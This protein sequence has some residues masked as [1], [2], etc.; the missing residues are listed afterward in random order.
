MNTPPLPE[1]DLSAT[2]QCVMCG[3]CVPHCPTYALTRNEADSPRGRIALMLGMHQ[4]R[5]EADDSTR[6]H[7]ASCLSCRAC[8]RICP[9]KVPYGQLIDAARAR[10]TPLH[11]PPR[12]I[13]WLRDGVLLRPARLRLFGTWWRLL[14]RLNLDRLPWPR[15]LARLARLV[16]PLVP[17][18]RPR[19]NYPATGPRRGAI[20]LFLGC[21]GPVFEAENL[22]AAIRVLNAWGYDVS[23]PENQ[24]CCGAMHQHGGD[25]ARGQTMAAGVETTFQPLGLDAV[26][27]VSSGCMAQLAEHTDLPVFELSDFLVRHV[28]S[29]LP[30]LRAIER[31][32]AVHLPCTQRNVLR[33]PDSALNLLRLIHGLSV[34]ALPGNDRCCGAAGT[35]MLT[36]PEQADALRAPKI[37]AF[38]TLGSDQLCSTNIGCAM[39]LGAGLR[40]MERSAEVIHPVR[41]L[42]E[43]LTAPRITSEGASVGS[44][45]PGQ[46]ST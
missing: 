6:A 11:S 26:V 25:P 31:Q 1:H 21:M 22:R 30:A 17:I 18:L 39:H 8:E 5:L 35:H 36:H 12:W 14:Q 38:R 10:I 29:P 33:R 45:P 19:A 44:Q 2:E 28:P 42:A 15:P 37:E 16:P 13:T 4:G 46:S 23:I 7:L 41:L 43:A 32:V 9:S 34:V 20:G 40:E 27:G 3:M 24:G